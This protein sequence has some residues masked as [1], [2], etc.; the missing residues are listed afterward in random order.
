MIIKE[1]LIREFGY[2]EEHPEYDLESWKSEVAD[3]FT[4]A[5]Y[6]DWVASQLGSDEFERKT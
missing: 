3:D 1:E 5:S 4:R 6:W 2:W